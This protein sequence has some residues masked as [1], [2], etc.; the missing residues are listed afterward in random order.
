MWF[1]NAELYGSS[2]ESKICLIE[3]FIINSS[4]VSS[5][6][7]V[8]VPLPR[9]FERYFSGQVRTHFSLVLFLFFLIILD[10][11]HPSLCNHVFVESK[12]CSGNNVI[13]IWFFLFLFCCIVYRALLTEL[14]RLRK[15]SLE[16][17]RRKTN[18]MKSTGTQ[19]GTCL[20]WLVNWRVLTPL[21]ANVR[22][23][24]NENPGVHGSYIKGRG[25][26]SKNLN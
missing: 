24:W 21:Y 11:F 17:E 23:E 1:D 15:V 10:N 6:L 12:L 16:N 7:I 3:L 5:P 4:K 8:S 9:S 19:T 2:N 26:T 20:K 25:C 13:H 14:N 18:E 22:L